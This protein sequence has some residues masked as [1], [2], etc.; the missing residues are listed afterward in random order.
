MRKNVQKKWLSLVLAAI[1]VF[2][3]FTGCSGNSGNGTIAKI[4]DASTSDTW[5]E[6]PINI[7]ITM[8][9]GGDGDYLTRL[10]AVELEKE[11][12]TSLVIT[13]VAGGNGSVGMDELMSAD[14]DGYTFYINN[15]CALAA[16]QANG[17][18]DYD[19]TV[20]DPVGVFA[21]HSGE[22]IW[23]RA[24]SPYETMDDLVKATQE[25][26]GKV[27]LGVSMGGSVYAAAMMLKNA[28]AEF[29]LVD[30]SDGADR[31]I[32]LLGGQV[33]SCIAGYGIGKEYIENGDLRP[34]CTLMG[35]RSAD[36]PDVPTAVE[37]GVDGLVINNLFV[38]LAPKG[39]DPEIIE[40]MNAAIRKITEENAEYAA[41]CTAY[42]GQD[43]Y[44]LSVED[45]IQ[46]LEDTK[47]QFMAISELL[48]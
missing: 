10:L 48:Q 42:S 14:A 32:A 16:N 31:I 28:G 23:V 35:S 25:N 46:V 7:V 44:A 27:S 37:A 30:A 47:S 17:L 15:T 38:A 40:K 1:L 33:D 12:G 2:T 39:T 41:A 29:S 6:K 5:P 8:S 22:M 34:L 24:D 26:P 45:T 3:L 43:A 18:V 4:D 21:K 9:A 13:N 20:S 36:L 11:L 19:Y